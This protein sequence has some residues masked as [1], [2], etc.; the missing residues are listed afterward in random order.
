MP[1]TAPVYKP[2]NLQQI[3][4]SGGL[5]VGP[6]AAANPF[7]SIFDAQQHI[8]YRD[9]KGMIFDSWLDGATGKWNLQH[10]NAG[11]VTNGPVA[12]GGPFIWVVSQKQQHFTYRDIA[13]T[14]WDSWYDGHWNLQQI[15]RVGG[16]TSAPAAAGDPAASIF[17]SQQH[18]GYR[19]AEGKIWDSWYD[20]H[21][22]LQQINGV[23]GTGV[24]K[25]PAASGG[26]FIWTVGSQQHFTYRDEKETI[27]DSWYDGHWNLQQINGAGGLTV[28]PP[29]KGDPF[30]AAFGSQQHV[31]YRDAAGTIW[32]SWYDGH[33]W[34]LQHLNTPSGVTPQAPPAA[35]DPFAS[36]YSRQ[37]H[38]AYRDA[39]GAIWDSWYDFSLSRWNIQRINASGL[40]AGPAA[41][42]GPFV[43]TVGTEQQ[44][45]TYRDQKGTIWD[46]WYVAPTQSVTFVETGIG[47]Y[48]E[49][50]NFTGPSGNPIP[51]AIAG[52]PF[53]MGANIVN[54]GA[55][56]A[57][58][59]TLTVVITASDNSSPQVLSAAV[60]LLPPRG[61]AT[62][63]VSVPAL[64][65]GLGYDFNFYDPGSTG[66]G[67][68]FYQF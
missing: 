42:G 68:L 43:W 38:V 24:T 12:A 23:G 60:P 22:S 64:P 2:W 59:S 13:G 48:I 21:W 7:A 19:D 50:V 62:A 44:H 41:A 46:S 5:T 16:V 6:A 36:I 11:G 66:I 30:A 1:A 54:G 40:T 45:F 33:G 56:K 47:L 27:W 3:N 32:D 14:I 55:V 57:A 61:G 15:N 4:A 67:H 39:L 37:M 8:A 35:G 17:G 20:G 25:G 34:S 63:W 28:G 29:A 51:D 53:K 52:Q 49:S 10:I 31:F 58:A 26:P 18:I 9:P 65:A